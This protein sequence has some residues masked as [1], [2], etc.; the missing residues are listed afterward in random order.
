[1]N[2]GLRSA[3]LR[4]A[5][6]CVASA[7]LLGGIATH[8]VADPIRAGFNSDYLP[9]ND[10][11]STGAVS[12][13]FTVNFFGNAH[14]TVFV[15][16]NGN[17]TFVTGLGT[18]TPFDLTSTSREII[19]PFF[20]DVDTRNGGSDVLRYGTGF[21]GTRPA[22]GANWLDVGYY[23]SQAD[24]LNSFQ[25][26][27]IDRTDV[28]AGDFDI[29]FNYRQV[30]WETG[31]ASGGSGGLGG[32]S[33]R[34][35][36]SN[37]TGDAGTFFELP[38]SA[39]NGAFLDG[40]P[41]SLVSGSFNSSEAGRYLFQVRNGAAVIPGLTPDNPFLPNATFPGGPGTPP[42]F[43]FS[44]VPSG[45]WFDPP[46]ATGFTY[47]MTSPGSLFTD[48]LAFPG[49]FGD[50][51]FLSAAGCSF[52]NPFAIGPVNFATFCGGSGVSQFSLT[53][54]TPLVDPADPLAFP[55]QLAFNT[56]T[57]SFTMQGINAVPEPGTLS[58]LC[59]AVGSVFASRARRPSRSRRTA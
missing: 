6:V 27:L 48:I 56:P 2:L 50:N 18:F 42:V 32:F 55:I 20:A 10:D 16:N 22:F 21:V 1:M 45:R 43:F 24:K 36:W 52:T 29:E 7:C 37:G 40:G 51:F 46:T 58:L 34:A 44:N 17:L 11:G 57:A 13:P 59:L 30:R 35:G 8:A 25:A 38:G 41:N 39:I 54:I 5:W 28:G 3:R 12:L 15:N 9:R 14:D 49:G 19:A 31:S 33:A 47:T 23:N 53:G 26:L 4:I